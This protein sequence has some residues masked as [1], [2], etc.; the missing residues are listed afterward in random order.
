M[1]TRFE[2]KITMGNVLTG[3]GM[4]AAVIIAYAKLDARQAY[5]ESEIVT[6]EQRVDNNEVRTRALEQGAATAS[7]RYESLVDS[8]GEVKVEVRQTNDLIRRLL[9]ER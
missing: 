5:I 9:E 8:L 3:V 1:T 6:I 7:A 2:N 4:L